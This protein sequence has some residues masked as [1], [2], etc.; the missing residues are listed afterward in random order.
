VSTIQDHN[1]PTG[2]VKGVGQN[3][4]HA[5]TCYQ[6]DGRILYNYADKVC[7]SIY[8]CVPGFPVI[9]SWDCFGDDGRF[10]QRVT[11]NGENTADA[12][13]L[14]CNQRLPEC[15]GRCVASGN[16]SNESEC[17]V[18]TRIDGCSTPMN[19]PVSNTY[20]DK[21]R[22]ACDAHDACYHAPFD[23]ISDFWAG[24][25][26]CNNNFWND[27]NAIC[28]GVLAARSSPQCGWTR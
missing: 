6:D 15:H 4:Y 1:G 28:G 24:F 12:A 25:N 9:S 2:A 14:Q 5:F 7:R 16:A 22:T 3:N 26:Q 21:F 8:R 19:D 18:S 27:M 17:N 23:S 11:F 20:K 13:A 10:K